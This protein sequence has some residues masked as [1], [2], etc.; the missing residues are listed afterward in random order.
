MWHEWRHADIS[1]HGKTLTMNSDIPHGP[2]TA[3]SLALQI[4]HCSVSARVDKSDD[5][6]LGNMDAFNT[7]GLKPGIDCLFSQ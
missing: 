3:A 1:C 6:D 2:L 4:R 5:H 7:D